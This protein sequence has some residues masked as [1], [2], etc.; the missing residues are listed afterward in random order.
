M[1]R[2]LLSIL[3]AGLVVSATSTLGCATRTTGIEVELMVMP[4]DETLL[5]ENADLGMDAL[6]LTS[7][8][9]VRCPTH[10]S[11]S[12]T[13]SH[14]PQASVAIGEAPTARVMGL[15][16]GS[17]CDVRVGLSVPNAAP[18]ETVLRVGCA[19][20][21]MPIELSAAQRSASLVMTFPGTLDVHRI[22][23]ADVDRQ[24]T[25][26][27]LVRGIS[28]DRIDCESIQP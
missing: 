17:Y 26:D 16:P 14:A 7:L 12:A 18:R 9:L 15:P 25:F 27:A 19:D 11:P 13:H 6:S 2:H 1:S 23:E 4:L 21:R 24:R 22:G 5:E 3:L 8:E 10:V 20:G 28:I